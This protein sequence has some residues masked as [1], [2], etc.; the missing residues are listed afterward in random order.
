VF[1]SINLD[2]LTCSIQCKNFHSPIWV[3][4]LPYG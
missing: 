3:L 2:L 4:K 1:Y